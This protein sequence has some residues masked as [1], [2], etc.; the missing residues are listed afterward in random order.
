MEPDIVARIFDPFFTTKAVGEGTG[1]GLAVVHG[2]V[3]EH[4]GHVA[5][6]SRIGQGTRFDIC[7]PLAGAG[8]PALAPEE[9]A[10]A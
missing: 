4:G 9:R 6:D 10:V 1:L 5:V 8:A 2:I 7:F 3:A